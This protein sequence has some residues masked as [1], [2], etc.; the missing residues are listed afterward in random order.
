MREE[1]VY[2]LSDPEHPE[3][4]KLGCSS[5]SAERIGELKNGMALYAV[6]PVHG[7]AEVCSQLRRILRAC[8][9][10]VESVQG[11]EFQCIRPEALLK[12]LCAAAQLQ[13]NPGGVRKMENESGRFV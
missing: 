7:A 11:N 13:G 1:F 5:D 6:Y 9:V 10:S 12:V 2:L 4:A 3:W 8:N